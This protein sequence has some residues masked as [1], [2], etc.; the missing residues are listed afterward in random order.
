M[1]QDTARRVNIDGAVRSAARQLPEDTEQWQLEWIIG[2]C[3]LW[4]TDQ[5]TGK[6]GRQV[7][8][9]GIGGVGDNALMDR[10]ASKKD[11]YY[12]DQMMT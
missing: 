1:R 11:K 10:W 3:W 4:F 7:T 12:G 9:I 2:S 8:M 5:C 6:G